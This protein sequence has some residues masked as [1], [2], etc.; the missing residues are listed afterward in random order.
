MDR[1]DELKVLVVEPGKKPYAK[2]IKNELKSLQDEVG[3]YIEVIHLL[4]YDV[5]LICDDEGKMKNSPFNRALYDSD[6][7]IYDVICGTFL[8]ADSE[9]GDFV[10]LSDEKMK[11]LLDYY[12]IPQMFFLMDDKLVALPMLCDENDN[13]SP[14]S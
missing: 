13:D 2:T 8:I 10:S 12:K 9:D 3:G 7:D 5:D 4:E 6:G 11:A 1:I 14:E